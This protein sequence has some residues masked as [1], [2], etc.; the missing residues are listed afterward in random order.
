MGR[1]AGS[2]RRAHGALPPPLSADRW[3]SPRASP[4]GPGRRTGTIRAIQPIRD[5]PGAAAT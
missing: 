4:P 1:G 2:G 5:E 3:P